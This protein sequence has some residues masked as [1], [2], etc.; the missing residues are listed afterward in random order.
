MKWQI[1]FIR[2]ALFGLLPFPEAVRNF[3][4]RLCPYSAAIDEWVLEQGIRQVQMLATV[5]H[6]PAGK[7][8]LELGTGWKPI[9]PIV[10]Y[11]SG[12]N[13]ILLIDTQR[14]LDRELIIGVAKNLRE[15]KEKISSGL[16]IS[17]EDVENKLDIGT[18]R[19]FDQLL[20]H[21]SMEYIA[22]CNILDITL[23]EKSVDII[24]SRAV[25]EHM[26]PRTV[27]DTH[28]ICRSILKDEG[29]LC[30]I[31]DNSDHWEH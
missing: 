13:K 27:L 22:P 8:I 11:L 19:S 9:I 12:C 29:K 4:R 2:N 25:L 5:G 16:G 26:P 21:F 18:N 6:S 15:Y 17:I 7:I 28:V 1:K 10:F 24:I 14:L 31:I 20:S 23:P 3:K 30:H